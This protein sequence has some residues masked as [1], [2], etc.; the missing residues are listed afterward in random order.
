M[1]AAIAANW[2]SLALIGVIAM[3][4]A[5]GGKYVFDIE[6]QVAANTQQ[7]ALSRFST[8]SA[9]REKFGH[10]AAQHSEWCALG[11]KLSMFKSCPPWKK[12]RS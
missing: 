2:K 11:I 7:L 8:L 3:S 9:I 4:G 5:T 10:T 6:R 1:L 12:Q